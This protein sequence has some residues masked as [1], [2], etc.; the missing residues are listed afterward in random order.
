MKIYI[1]GSTGM[2]GGYIKKY[3]LQNNIETISINRNILDVSRISYSKLE[4]ILRSYKIDKND[5]IINCIGIIPQS[6]YINNT[7]IK[8]YFLINSIFPNMLS[9]I[10][11]HYKCKFIHITTDCVFSGKKGNYDENDDHD[12]TSDYGVSKS[13]GELGC[14]STIIRTSII[15]E[16]EKNKYSLLEWV[17]SHK[18]DSINGYINHYWNGVT[19]LQLAKII[20]EI[21]NKNIW[22]YG[23]RHIYS[24]VSV[25]KYEL[26]SI[27]NDVYNLNN[28]I[29][30][31]TTD[32]S[33]N[34][35]LTS[36]YKQEVLDKFNIPCIRDQIHALK[37]FEF[38]ASFY[39]KYEIANLSK[40]HY[41]TN[42]L[43]L[44]S[45]LSICDASYI[46]YNNFS[47]FVDEL[48][49]NHIIKVLK[50]KITNKIIGSITI[51]IE[52]KLIHNYS[53]VG[54]IE[55]LIIDHSYRGLGLGKKLL[56]IAKRE[57]QNCYKIILNCNNDNI[58]FY[59]KCGYTESLIQMRINN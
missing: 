33:I 11:N 13:L 55:D 20:F 51:L 25:S 23:V 17:L 7:T 24:P 12:E 56:Y 10:S 50:D 32:I 18:N 27:I 39:N 47:T 44:L 19:C 43:S 46:T 58:E 9:S 45:Q 22:W 38:D 14:K 4:H 6:K 36:L 2:L 37:Q 3:L 49:S 34:K 16:E 57:C 1:F 35:T 8:N 59:N 53:K 21:I 15:G 42:Y 29:I 41:Y 54:H 5:I 28:T 52:N 26:V 31:T 40:N 48:N 30:P